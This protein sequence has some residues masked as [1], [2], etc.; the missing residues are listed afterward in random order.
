M[1]GAD[2]SLYAGLSGGAGSPSYVLRITATGT[3]TPYEL[4]AGSTANPGVLA[5]G[6]DKL[7]WMEGGGM[8]TS[9]TTGGVFADYP[10][11]SPPPRAMRFA[12]IAADPSAD[13][14]W[15]T[16]HTAP[17]VYRVVLAPPPPPPPPPP[18]SPPPPP[19]DRRRR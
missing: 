12:G 14:L 6:P 17:T 4:P 7:L 8:L 1:L 10:A 11:C 5:V 3:I 15:L 16:D 19:A 9:M 2:G 18:P 13:A